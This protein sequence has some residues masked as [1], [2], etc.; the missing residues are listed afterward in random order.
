[1]CPTAGADVNRTTQYARRRFAFTR[2]P[3][4]SCSAPAA[5]RR[6]AFLAAHADDYALA[7]SAAAL[8]GVRDLSNVRVLLA[9][10]APVTICLTDK[11]A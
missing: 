10:R 9:D 5:V 1:M 6:A 4:R 3:S 11:Q 2:R 8:R 7:A